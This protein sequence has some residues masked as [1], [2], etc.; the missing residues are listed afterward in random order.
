[1]PSR[2]LRGLLPLLAAAMLPAAAYAQTGRTDV[3]RLFSALRFRSIGPAVT[4]GRVHDIE[5]LPDNPSVIYVATATGGIW[6]TE[7]KGTTW[8][9]I[10]DREPVST[11]GDIAIAP[12]NHDVLYVGTGEQNNR[13]SSSWG[14]G[15]YRSDDAGKTWQHVGLDDTRAI[16]KVI[17]NPGDPDIVY[18]AALGN[19]WKPGAERGV[20]KT[21][22]GGHTWQKVLYVDTL[23]GAVDLVMDPKD[24]NTLYAATYQRLRRTWG[25]NG[26]GP[27]SGIW[28]T[29]DGGA[30]WMR[31]TNGLPAGDKGRI[32]LA[33]A[34]TNPNV[35]NAIIQH[36]EEGGVYR[37]EDGGQSWKKVNDQNIRP[38]YY[39]EI[40]ID[41]T[42]ENRV[43][44]LAT[45]SFRSEDGGRTF[46]EI[47]ARVTYDVGVH[48]DHHALWIDPNNPD[49]FYLGG[50]AGLYETW[51]R[52][53]SYIRI[54][55]FP[56]GQFYGIGVDMRD[57]YWIYGG[58]QDNHSWMG[59][60]ATRHWAGIIN[61]DWR[62]IGFGDGMFDQIDTTATGYRHVFSNSNDGNFTRVDGATGDIM[63]IMPSPPNGEQARCD[64]IAPTLVSRHDPK[65]VY[66][67][68]NRLYISHDRGVSWSYTRD[69]SRQIDR[70]T[71]KLMGVEGANI[72]ISKN[73]GTGSYGEIVAIAESPLD[74][75]ILWV[76]T[77]DGN[78]QV[79]RDGG[80]TWTEV[81]QNVHGVR[82]GT[83]VSRVTAS[84]S[85]PGVA[86]ATFDAHRD[87]DFNPYVFRTTDFG[88]TWTRITTGLEGAGS[89]HEIIEHPDNPDVLFLG[90]EHALWIS[91]DRG[92]HWQRFGANLPT[93]LYV[94]M[95]IHPREKDL[96]VAT[97][98]RSLWILD[99]VEFLGSWSSAVAAEPAH[100]FPVRRATIHQYWKDTSYRGQNFYAGTNA[101]FGALIRYYLGRA[102]KDARIEVTAPDGS[103]VRTLTVPGDSG[104]IET[105]RWDLRHEPPPAGYSGGE[106]GGAD[107]PHPIGPRGPFVSPGTY[108]VTLIAGGARAS[109]KVVVRGDPLMPLTDAQYRDREAFLLSVQEMQ[110]KVLQAARDADQ[111]RRQLRARQDSLRKAGGVPAGMAARIDSV[112]AL[113]D[114]LNRLRRGVFG[115]A[116]QFTGSGAQQGSLYPPTDTQKARKRMLEAQLDEQLQALDE[117]RRR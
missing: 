56:I 31:L 112:S 58:M 82:N 78:L 48:S 98:G 5:A 97:H 55:N 85:G 80:Q 79:S 111:L 32:G 91:L 105:V 60:S 28:K 92:A 57:P 71:L 43:Y 84:R 90:S 2:T 64:W 11:F 37:T 36:P 81:S 52:G 113:G 23:T 108:T 24:P 101:P 67:G 86:Y 13:Q 4:G 12:S 6:K 46:K 29:M 22:D 99:D 34:R 54:N 116:S 100:L 74:G 73:D 59:P 89:V 70:D 95:L 69:L 50:D 102:A 51:D 63:D 93:T 88:Q 20:F 3:P 49:H 47:S 65:T 77:D 16:G 117:Q 21:T 19:L 44:T 107:L 25:F 26:G 66:A 45:R 87:G 9:P 109:Q 104:V 61:D 68:C 96:V 42:N 114:R 35:L 18:V 17:V 33:I 53:S 40:F 38:M 72:S 14:D 76:G 39:S 15:V 41:P 94:D 27:G 62:Q 8:T 110:S 83:Y 7:N 30:H 103:R 1:M 106:Q 115:L 10:F 75:R